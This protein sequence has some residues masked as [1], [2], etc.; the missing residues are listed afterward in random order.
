MAQAQLLDEI[1]PVA[2]GIVSQKGERWRWPGSGA[3]SPCSLAISVFRL[4][5]TLTGG[6][7][8]SVVST[9]TLFVTFLELTLLAF[10]Y[11]LVAFMMFAYGLILHLL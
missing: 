11:G 2:D 5:T 6:L 10:V 8:L 7:K 3:K 4:T 9:L 1:V